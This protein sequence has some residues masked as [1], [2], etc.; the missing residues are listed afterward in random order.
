MQ[1]ANSTDPKKYL[2][3]L[4]KLDMKGVTGRV[5]FE[6]NGELKNAA[7][8]LFTYKDGKKVALN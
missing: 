3:E 4:A 5:Q 1:K 2:A 6:S 8:T 7:V